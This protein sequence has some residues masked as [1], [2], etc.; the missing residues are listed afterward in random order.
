MKMFG[1][2]DPTTGDIDGVICEKCANTEI[3][4]GAMDARSI[5]RLLIPDPIKTCSLCGANMDGLYEN[6]KTMHI[7]GPGKELKRIGQD[8]AFDNER[9]AWRNAALEAVKELCRGRATFTADD[10]RMRILKTGLGHPHHPNVWGS[11][12]RYAA[13]Q[14]W[15]EK[16]G[17]YEP[18]TVASRHAGMIQVWRSLIA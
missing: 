6:M 17:N 9:V 13:A 4:C 8:Q 2:E 10:V 3:K 16:T 7:P 18:S 15:A 12:M 14:H 11:L 5:I 1:I